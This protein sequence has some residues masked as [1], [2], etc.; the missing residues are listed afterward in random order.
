VTQEPRDPNAPPQT[1]EGGSPTPPEQGGAPAQQS[2]Q[3]Q[4]QQPAAPPAGGGQ[5]AGS[6]SPAWVGTL[7]DQTPVPGPAGY[8]YADVPNR[9][10]AMIIDVI[11]I[12]IVYFIVGVVTLAIFGTETIFGMMTANPLVLITQS[13]ISYAI[14]AAYFLYTWVNMRGTFGM[15]ALGL[16]IGHQEDGRSLTYQEAAY[17][18]GVL[19]GPII[20]IGLVTSLIPALSGLGLLSFLW[21]IYVLYTMAQSPTKQGIHDRYG[22]SM[23]VKGGRSVA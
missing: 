16:Q 19:F 20:V 15:K 1:P 5:P 14:W 10:I 9:S 21:F 7:T 8:F 2:W 13:L 22:Q 12:I 6:G 17:R 4:P 23:V 11:G 18:F 3:S